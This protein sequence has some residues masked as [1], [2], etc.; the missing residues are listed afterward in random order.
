MK[1]E[2][3]IGDVNVKVKR[4]DFNTAFEYPYLCGYT[5]EF[6]IGCYSEDDVSMKASVSYSDEQLEDIS[7]R[8]LLIELDAY[9]IECDNKYE[10]WCLNREREQAIELGI[11]YIK[12]I[13]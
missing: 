6:N 12:Q 3:I 4:Y 9:I 10:D 11:E 7:G 13:K 2:I 1:R 5:F 8:D